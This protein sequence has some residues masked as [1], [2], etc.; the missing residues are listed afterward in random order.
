MR[1]VK[2]LLM[3]LRLLAGILVVL[4]IGFWSGHWS[5]LRNLHMAL[6]ALFVL[7][8]W[9]LAVL[10]LTARRAVGLAVFALIWGVVIAG[11]GAAQQGLLV[12]D[13]HWIVRIVHLAIALAA[14]PIAER[15]AKLPV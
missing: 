7:V 9:S 8:L 14:M 2:P 13:L 5:G 1:A 11:F 15:L 4:G 10:A 6:G 12:G 3:L